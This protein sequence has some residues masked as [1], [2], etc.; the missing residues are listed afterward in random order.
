MISEHRFMYTSDKSTTDIDITDMETTEKEH[1]LQRTQTTG[2]TTD[3][4][5]RKTKD[6][7]D[8]CKLQTKCTLSTNVHNRQI[9]AYYRQLFLYESKG[10]SLRVRSISPIFIDPITFG[11]KITKRNSQSSENSKTKFPL[12]RK[13]QN[14]IPRCPKFVIKVLNQSSH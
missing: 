12:V 11:P 3:V 13:F 1:H 6:T 5:T 10:F 4:S 14:K 7:I 2:K 8:K 9:N